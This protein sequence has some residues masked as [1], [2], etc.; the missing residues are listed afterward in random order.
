VC[1]FV[2]DNLVE[3]FVSRLNSTST[4]VVISTGLPFR[5]PGQ[6]ANPDRQQRIL[7]E[8]KPSPLQLATADI[9]VRIHVHFGS[10]NSVNATSAR[11]SLYKGGV[12]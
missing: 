6:I 10:N 4:R 2:R 12:L 11:S 8:A 1:H 5:L 7:I 3:F 9:A